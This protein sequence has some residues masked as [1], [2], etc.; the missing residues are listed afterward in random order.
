MIID[1]ELMKKLA[2][3]GKRID[4]RDADSYRQIS[5]ENDVIT[6]AEGSCR[7]RIG[8]THVIAGVKIGTGTPFSDTPEEGVLM[9]AAE[10]LPLASSEFE[11]GPPGEEAIEL[12]RVVDRAIRESKAIDFEKLCITPKEKVWMVH[13]D[14]DVLDDD[15]NLL[16]AACLAAVSA[17]LNAKLPE[18]DEEKNVIY[19]TKTSQG[20]P[21]TGK[22]VSNTF[23]K[24]NGRLFADPKIEELDASDARLTVGSIEKDGKFY[25]C[26]MQKGGPEG[27]ALSDIEQIISM[28][29]QKSKELRVMI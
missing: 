2:E 15:G 5:I 9:V 14:I 4:N 6:S 28:A 20:L 23:V 18:I 22:P 12:A 27:F 26:S 19:G 25:L 8:D 11:S 13:V 7:V 29:E 24:I 17:L 10:L 21:I 3:K 1:K 16:D